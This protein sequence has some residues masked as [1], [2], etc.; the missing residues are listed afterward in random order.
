M[1]LSEQLLLNHVRPRPDARLTDF[2][3]A[4]YAA[5]VA[6]ARELLHQ[7]GQLL[8]VQGN[9]GYGRSH[10][11][12]ALCAEAEVTGLSAVL[13]PLAELA[14]VSPDVLEGLETQE[15]LAFDDVQAIAGVAAWEEGM[16]HLFNRCR[17]T[18]V[19]LVFAGENIPTAL[20]LRLPDLVSRLSLA[21]V[22]RLER[23]DD[24]SREALIVAAARRRGWVL[25]A[26]V[27][28]YLVTRAPREPGRLLACLEHLDQESLQ[29]ARRLTIPFVR[30]LL[31]APGQGTGQACEQPFTL[32]GDGGV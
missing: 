19:R 24:A 2:A 13:L 7:P 26:E 4:S 28:R 15:L 3:G 8:Y 22:W 23:P 11:L 14:Q 5:L 27:L 30:A 16:F 6:A 12:A 32:P 20:G 9:S 1:R 29:A 10:F 31:E 17:S 18:G 21:P 25:E